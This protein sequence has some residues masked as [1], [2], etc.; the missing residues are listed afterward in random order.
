MTS[1]AIDPNSDCGTLVN[2]KLATLAAATRSLRTFGRKESDA[3]LS[4]DKRWAAQSRRSSTGDRSPVGVTVKVKTP[5]VDR[6]QVHYLEPPTG[7]E[8]VTCCLQ[9]SCS[10]N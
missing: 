2:V 7:I 1:P 3:I 10:A 8:P 6:F 9:N 4:S 5:P